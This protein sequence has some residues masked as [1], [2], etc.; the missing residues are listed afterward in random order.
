MLQEGEVGEKKNQL[1]RQQVKQVTHLGE[2]HR[3][4]LVTSLY[5]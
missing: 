3:I 2:N 5:A 1:S 4:V